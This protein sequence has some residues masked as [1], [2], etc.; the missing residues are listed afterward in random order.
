[1][2]LN[3]ENVKKILQI[4]IEKDDLSKYNQTL[5]NIINHFKDSNDLEKDLLILE[6]LSKEFGN[7]LANAMDY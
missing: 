1:M 5:V 2:K 7:I 3:L 6:S 4:S